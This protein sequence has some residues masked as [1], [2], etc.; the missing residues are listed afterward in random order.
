M[1]KPHRQQGRNN[2]RKTNMEKHKYDS[3]FAEKVIGSPLLPSDSHEEEGALMS[4]NG[5]WYFVPHVEDPVRGRPTIGHPEGILT[6]R[7]R[8][9]LE[10]AKCCH[11]SRW[12]P[13]EWDVVEVDRFDSLTLAIAGTA[14]RELDQQIAEHGSCVQEIENRENPQPTE[15]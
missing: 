3:L 5:A 2:V 8:W 9:G 12:E 4:K 13:D 10:T 1:A 15:E 11:G 14:H 7:P 6:T